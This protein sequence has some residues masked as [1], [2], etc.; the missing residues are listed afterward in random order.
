MHM[1]PFAHYA[2]REAYLED[3]DF[4]EV[5]QQLQ[6]QSHVHDGDNIVDYHVQD[7]LLYRMDKVCVHKGERL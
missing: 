2:Y 7:Y 5:Y 1:D 3:E 6:N 4:K